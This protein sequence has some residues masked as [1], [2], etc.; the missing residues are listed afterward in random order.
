MRRFLL[1]LL[2][3]GWLAGSDA[4]AADWAQWRGP[5]QNGVSR[6]RDLP[7]R[8]NTDPSKPDSNVIW[9]QPIGG[10]STPIIMNGRVYLIN[11]AGEGI[12]E[13]ERVMCFDADTGKVLWEYKFNVFHTDIVSSRVGWTNLAGDPETGNIYAQ[14]VQ[15]LF[16]C[17]DKDGKLLWSHSLTEE[18]GRISGYGGRVTSPTVDGDLCIVGMVNAS[19]G[20]QARPGNRYLA[21][22]KRTGEPVWWSEVGPVPATYYSTPVVAVI[23]GERLLITGGSD[24]FV[25]G[26]RVRTGEQIWKYRVGARAINNA[27]VVDGTHVYVG[28]GEENVDTNTRGRVVCLD[29][30]H[31]EKGQ[32]KLVWKKDGIRNGYVSSILHDGRLYVCDDSGR[33]YCLD[34][35]T[36]K[37]HWTYKYGRDARGSPVWA[38]GKI[39][40]GEVAARFHI[41]KPEDK[42]CRELY[43]QFFQS[44]SGTAVVEV[45]S[46]PAIVNGRIYFTTRDE[47]YCLGKK[48]WNGKT[49]PIPPSPQETPVEANA[50]PAHLQVVPADVVL[51][52]GESAQFKAR[53]FD[54]R[55]HLLRE[56]PAEWSL[57]TPPPPAA[58]PSAPGGAGATS[59]P[60]SAAGGPPAPTPPP[61][62]GQINAE[63]KLFVDKQLPGQQ[64][65][66]MATAENLSGR[67]RVRVVPRL[68]YVQD[69]EKI[70][71]G[72]TPG[73]W[74]NAQGKF[75]VV[76]TKTGK[77]LK[78]TAENPNPSV[79]RANAF[80]GMPDL[81]DYTIQVDLMGGK[82]SN[83]MPD[84]GVVANRYHLIL[85]G[86]KQRLRIQSWDTLPRVD[87][88]LEWEWKP[89]VWYRMK[90]TVEL[91]GDKA[92]VRGKVWDRDKEEPA[93][94]TIEF[95]DPT[96]NKEGSPALY[97]Y[98]TGILGNPV[99]A[100]V[101]YD[102]LR[103]TPNKKVTTKR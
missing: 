86:N 12:N 20:D 49:D 75:V 77:V 43:T 70:P 35:A 44:P 50:Q 22:D 83:D 21:V 56:V 61:L 102:N 99:G 34:A 66:A 74:I 58:P 88:S 19:W 91:Q 65:A 3:A 28:H 92:Q 54:A 52:P 96:P 2:A 85:D 4:R 32:P 55:G 62:R 47:F 38:D 101:F 87:K 29:A 7:D 10:R 100:E 79:A 33:M 68:P 72:R 64:G 15:G 27:P 57:P 5:E 78:K 95:T 98:A 1:Y 39:Y 45:N 84:M 82:A 71:V 60:R 63:G 89:D 94:W 26:L 25:H 48:N 31:I 46:T 16:L 51:S 18:Y 13:Q 42:R 81:S 9:K 24:G 37:Q 23:N 53:A 36:G 93:D 90:L 6:D 59:G 67:A 97:G 76:E 30:G 73:G 8:F 11:D 80:I 69:F 40:I 103:L 41:L 17:F 14:G